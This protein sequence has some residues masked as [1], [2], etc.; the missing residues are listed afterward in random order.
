MIIYLYVKTHSVTGL[1]YQPESMGCRIKRSPDK[2][3]Y[4]N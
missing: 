2:Y 1:K 3:Y 4:Q